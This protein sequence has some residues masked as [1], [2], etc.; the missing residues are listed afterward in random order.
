MKIDHR[1]IIW[2]LIGLLIFITF[3]PLLKVGIVNGD[4]FVNL[5]W[6]IDHLAHD[7]ILYAQSTGRFYFIFALWIYKIPYLIDSETYF[8]ITLILPHIIALCLFIYLIFRLFKN[9]QL[10]MLTAVVSCVIFQIF[11]GNTATSGYPFYFTFTFSLILLSLHFLISYFNNH[12][13]FYLLLSATIFG[14][15]TIFYECYLI[16]YILIF[17]L[18]I[19]RYSLKSLFSKKIGFKFSKEIFPFFLFGVIYLV[20]YFIFFNTY[21]SVYQGN[22]ISSNLTFSRFLWTIGNLSLYSFPLSSLYDYR[23]FITDYSL[24]ETSSFNIFQIIFSEAGLEAYLKSFIVVLV[25]LM[26]QSQYKDKIQNKKLLFL[27]L[28]SIIFIFLPH[29][30]LSISAK[31]TNTIQNT[32]VTT[33]FSFFAVVIFFISL[34]LWF[35]NILDHKKIWRPIFNVAFYII[36]FLVTLTIQFVNQRV[37][38]DLNVAEKRFNVMEDMLKK[39]FIENGAPVYVANLHKSTSY[40]SKPITR[41]ASPFNSF[42]KMKNNLDIQQYLDYSTFYNQFKSDSGVVFTLYFSQASKTG[43]VYLSIL[44]CHGYELKENMNQNKGDSLWVGYFSKYKKFGIGISSDSSRAF[45]LEGMTMNNI[46]TF[47]FNNLNFLG[48][49]N[50][51]IFKIKGKDLYPVTLSIVNQLYPNIPSQIIGH[52]PKNYESAWVYHIMKELNKSKDFENLIRQKA[53]QNNISYKT[54]LK[55]DATWILYNEFQN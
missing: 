51:C 1:T 19:R 28:T 17:I 41:Q 44:R 53:I 5:I 33:Y 12:K 34:L 11:G 54:S 14:I 29:L 49:P 2:G 50:T 24:S 23:F 9:E 3:Y 13:Y 32:Y 6:P 22:Q 20:I 30:P 21:S 10:A 52:L 38:D 25:I 16:Y 26:I 15:V 42:V 31:Y 8:H 4:D 18:I 46:G 47:H 45:T 40:F 55:Q 48:S 36:I 43:D 37:C 35:K 27:I 39:E 7:S